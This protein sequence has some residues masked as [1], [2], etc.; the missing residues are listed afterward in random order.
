M[1]SRASIAALAA[2]LL[3]TGCA[4]RDAVPVRYGK[5]ECTLCKM[6]LVD[7]RFGAELIT[8]KGKVLLF[9]DMTCLFQYQQAN[10]QPAGT[11]VRAYVV[12]FAHP[13]T[14][15]PAEQAVFLVGGDI[16]SPMG[17]GIAAFA[18]A[19][20]RESARPQLGGPQLHSWADLPRLP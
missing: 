13:G 16:H 19:A 10:P 7:Q 11:A 5:D 12:D 17:G 18:R 4:P 3:L 8:S 14:L 2:M 1:R 6:T 20:D 15:V 9:D